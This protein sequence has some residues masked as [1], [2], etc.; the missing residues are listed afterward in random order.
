MT[1]CVTIGKTYEHGNLRCERG[2]PVLQ[3]VGPK[4]IYRSGGPDGKW[5]EY[6]PLTKEAKEAKIPLL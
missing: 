2:V 6:N 4:V 5:C 3:E 1:S